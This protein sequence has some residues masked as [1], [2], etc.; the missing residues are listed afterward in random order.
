MCVYGFLFR[1]PMVLVL[2]WKYPSAYMLSTTL[3]LTL[4][5]CYNENALSSVKELLGHGIDMMSN[6]KRLY[7]CNEQPGSRYIYN[8]YIQ[9]CNGTKSDRYMYQIFV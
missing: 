4:G 1:V 5:I 9:T 6:D 2:E 8:Q 3:L 7:R